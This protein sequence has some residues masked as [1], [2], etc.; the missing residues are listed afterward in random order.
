MD[1]APISA[2]ISNSLPRYRQMDLA[3]ISATISNCLPRFGKQSSWKKKRKISRYGS[4]QCCRDQTPSTWRRGDRARRAGSGAEYKA[5]GPQA[6]EEVP[7][8]GGR[9]TWA[10]EFMAGRR[11]PQGIGTWELTAEWIRKDLPSILFFI[12]CPLLSRSHEWRL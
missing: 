10:A 3:P 4:R 1:L 12:S 9:T 5:T 8:R 7:N 11:R 6:E 2:M